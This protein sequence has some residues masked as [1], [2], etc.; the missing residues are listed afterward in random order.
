MLTLSLCFYLKK[1]NFS[2]FLRQ[3]CSLHNS[4]EKWQHCKYRPIVIR[5]H[6]NLGLW[7]TVIV[8]A[9]VHQNVGVGQSFI[10]DTMSSDHTLGPFEK[11]CRLLLSNFFEET[12]IVKVGEYLL[13]RGTCSF[14][15]IKTGTGMSVWDVR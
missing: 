11:V 5:N 1:N 12:N 8:R 6:S 15:N 13:S 2:G 9:H 10:R 14:F 7:Y 3:P 4:L